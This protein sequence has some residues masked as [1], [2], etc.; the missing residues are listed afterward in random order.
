MIYN[1]YVL[2]LYLIPDKECLKPWNF[3]SDQLIMVKEMSSVTHNQP[4]LTTP[5]FI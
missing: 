2:G 5:E 4:L 3:L 1:E